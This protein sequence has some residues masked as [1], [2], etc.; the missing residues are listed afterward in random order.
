MATKSNDM[1]IPFKITR[2][3]I[4]HNKN[5]FHFAK[6]INFKWKR[7]NKNEYICILNIVKQTIRQYK[8]DK[9]DPFSHTFNNL[10]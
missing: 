7:D 8:I 2:D 1:F 10:A 6:R 3:T 4:F 9:V 5:C